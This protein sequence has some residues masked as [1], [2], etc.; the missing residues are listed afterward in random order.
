MIGLKIINMVSLQITNII[1]LLIMDM[2]GL[3]KEY[4]WPTDNKHGGFSDNEKLTIIAS[5]KY[6]DERE[7]MCNRCVIMEVLVA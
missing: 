6:I 7:Q 1:G 4:D 2:I 5:I 3:K